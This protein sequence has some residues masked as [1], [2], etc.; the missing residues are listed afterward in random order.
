MK[1]D[2]KTWD[3]TNIWGPDSEIHHFSP[4]PTFSVI[5]FS[6]PQFEALVFVHTYVG[7]E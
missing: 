3:W 2:P 4:A 1:S 5:F 6:G 7:K